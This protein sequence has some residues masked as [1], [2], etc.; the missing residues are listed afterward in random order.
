[1]LDMADLKLVENGVQAK[2]AIQ[3]LLS[4]G[5]ANHALDDGKLVVVAHHPQ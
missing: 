3:S 1:M 4:E 2:E 5:V